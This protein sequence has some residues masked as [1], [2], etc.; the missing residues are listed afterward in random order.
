MTFFPS[1]LGLKT[2]I[3]EAVKTWPELRNSSL[4]PVCRSPVI[5]RTK[6]ITPRWV[7]K[8]ELKTRACSGLSSILGEGKSEI[9]LSRRSATPSPVLAE[10]KKGSEEM[11]RSCLICLVAAE[12]SARGASILLMTGMMVR[13]R[14]RASLRFATVCAWTPLVASTR[15]TAPSQASSARSTS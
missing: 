1:R 9:I 2:P 7:S 4:S 5:T 6:A 14:F 12:T 15:R 11:L 3:S 10:I 13:P 8:T